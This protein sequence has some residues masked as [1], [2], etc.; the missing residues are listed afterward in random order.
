[1]GAIS[2]RMQQHHKHCDEQF[3]AAEEAV[4]GG[5]W[6]AAERAFSAFVD[7]LEGHFDAEENLLFTA[8]ERRTGMSGGPTQVMRLEHGQMRGLMDQMRASVEARD[9]SAFAG[10]AETLLIL[11]QQHNL[12]EENI[13][14]PMCDQSLQ[15]DVGLLGELDQA[16]RAPLG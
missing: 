13:L 6:A 14:Y 5:Q 3:A 15:G 10:A 4:H 8:F 11:M 12:K 9:A 7:D 1:M 16:L 2:E